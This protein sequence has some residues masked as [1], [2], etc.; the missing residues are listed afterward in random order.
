M[1]E[2]NIGYLIL[3]DSIVVN[4]DGKTFT[5]E[6]D[7]ELY[8]IILE[9][10]K[11]DDLSALPALI[12]DATRVKEYVEDN[13]FE[14]I[15]GIVFSHGEPVNKYISDKLVEFSKQKIPYTFL[16]NFWKL[17]KKNPSSNSV[18]QLYPFLEKARCPI[19]EDGY[20]IAYKAVNANMRDKHSNSVQYEIGTATTQDRSTI[21]DNPDCACGSGLHVGSYDYAVS[22][23]SNDTD[24]ILE[25]KVNPADVVSVPND[26]SHGKCRCCKVLPIGINVVGDL[27]RAIVDK[28]TADK[29]LHPTTKPRSTTFI[30][31][32]K[33]YDRTVIDDNTYAEFKSVGKRM[34]PSKMP[35]NIKSEHGTIAEGYRYSNKNGV[36]YY[37]VKDAQGVIQKYAPI[38]T[39]K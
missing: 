18:A 37:L 28:P 5:A 32:K 33:Q 22:F 6:K 3:K 39:K 7:N 19:T 11:N 15:D 16:L 12:D 17:L 34:R 4:H 38:A 14:I 36:V 35:K 13:E 10:I 9:H 20:F 8:D 27:K 30:I 31:N 1:S 21:S 2:V 24:I 26:A 29:N 23:G 25:V